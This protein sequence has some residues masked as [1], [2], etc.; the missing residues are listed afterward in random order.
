MEPVY[1]NLSTDEWERK[2]GYL[3][4]MFSDCRL[5]NHECGAD[6]REGE[7]GICEEG[8]T[9]R[10]A[11]IQP[12]FGEE[13]PLVGRKGS[14]TVF[15]SGCSMSCV[16]CQNWRISQKN[17]GDLLDVEE[18]AE[19]MLYLQNKGCHNINWVTPTHFAPLL[20]RS[21]HIASEKGLEIPVV[22][23]TGGYDNV[24]L[25]KG[26]EGVVDIYMPDV[27]YG[28][29]EKADK[30][31][32]AP[33]Y[34]TNIKEGLK[35]MQ[36]Q[37]GDLKT[38]ENDIAYRGILLRHLVLPGN[39]ADSEKVLGFIK[40]EVSD[41]CHVN[42]MGQYRPAYRSREYGKLSRRVKRKEVEK[43]REKADEIGL[44]LI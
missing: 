29:D 18:M 26:L 36:E 14:G 2:I 5:C 37:V 22:Y 7:K 42:I 39:L 1:K 40:E 3:T 4:D 38:D 34:W 43:A 8:S 16:Y 35:I 19:K 11:S 13:K 9:L 33:G 41:N 21:L 6:R 30:Y 28:S 27:K 31:S 25:L 20:V 12:H 44:K 17:E 24:E 15:L 32:S 10:I 23:N